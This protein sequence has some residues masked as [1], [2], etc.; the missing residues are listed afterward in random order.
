MKGGSAMTNF[1]VKCLLLAL[2]FC[3]PARAQEIEIGK[4]LACDQASQ[5]TRFLKIVNGDIDAAV[6]QVNTEAANPSACILGHFALIRGEET[7]TIRNDD[8][9]WKVTQILVVAIGTSNGW[10]RI[11]PLVQYTA[12]K[13]EER[14]A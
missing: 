14:G 2:L 9:T 1:L 7:E 13:L 4:G 12:F 6:R 5:I 8:G 10:Q 11:P 3:V